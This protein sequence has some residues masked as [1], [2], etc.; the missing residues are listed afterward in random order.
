MDNFVTDRTSRQLAQN[1]ELPQADIHGL[2]QLESGALRID[3]TAADGSFE[4]AHLA[5]P[6]DYLGVENLVGMQGSLAVRAITPARLVPVMV[7]DE[8]QRIRV[9]TEAFIQGT[10]AAASC[11]ACAMARRRCASSGCCTCW[12]TASTATWAGAL[13]ARCPA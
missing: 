7:Q 11:W 2:W 4:F 13:P 1:E 3:S 12:P 10:A 8:E 9:L 5:L 6:G